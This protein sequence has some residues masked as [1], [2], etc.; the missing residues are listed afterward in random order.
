MMITNIMKLRLS[1]CVPVRCLPSLR[2]FM[3]LVV[4]TLYF[5]K[6]IGFTSQGAQEKQGNHVHR[7]LRSF[8]LLSLL[9]SNNFQLAHC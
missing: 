5:S 2:P 1:S 8:E 4:T 3:F 6:N 9:A 7:S